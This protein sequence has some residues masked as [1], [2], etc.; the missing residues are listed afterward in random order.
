MSTQ[1]QRGT[2]EVVIGL[3]VPQIAADS[4]PRDK[5]NATYTLT[6]RELSYGSYLAITT[7]MAM[8]ADAE[9]VLRHPEGK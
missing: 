7:S 1:H 2:F 3:P 5:A 4:L 8:G 6:F 9:L